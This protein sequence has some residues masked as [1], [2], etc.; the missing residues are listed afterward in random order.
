M[1]QGFV[2]QRRRLPHL[3]SSFGVLFVTIRNSDEIPKKLLQNYYTHANLMYKADEQAEDPKESSYKTGK[4]LMAEFD[5]M[6]HKV[7][8]KLNFIKNPEVAQALADTI[9]E[10]SE[11]HYHL[12]AYTIMPNHVHLLI[13]PKE[14]DGKLIELSEILRFIK[15][16]SARK[17]NL[18]LGRK[19]AVWQREYYD[20]LVR[21][22]REF[23][24]IVGYILENPVKAGLM[25]YDEKW[26]WG[27]VNMDE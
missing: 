15:G 22:M 1:S 25:D 14:V 11:T 5:D 23:D 6:L 19:G 4:I 26:K 18:I 12:Y 2:F 8:T 24:N 7:D 20:H 16:R 9:H 3:Y 10:L 21:N 17:I 27:W 13:K